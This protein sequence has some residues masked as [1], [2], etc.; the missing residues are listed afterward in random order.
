MEYKPADIEKKWQDYWEEIGLFRMDP[1]D[2]KPKFYCLMMFP[3]PSGTLHVGHM[4]NY[5]IGDVLARYKMMKGFNV[6]SP[7]GWD[8]FGLP[9]ENAAI[10]QNV[11]PKVSTYN[12]IATIKRQL[13]EWGTGYDWDREIASCAPDY[14]KWTQWMFLKLY[15]RGLAYRKKAEVNWCPSCQTVLANEQV[16][17]EKCERC[18]ASVEKKDLE[19]W[20]FK[21]TDYA[22]RLLDDL[23]KLTRWPERVKIMQRNWIGRSEGV[24][25]DFALEKTG[26]VIKCFTTRVDTLFGATFMVMA[27]EHPMVGS[28]IEDAPNRKEIE[29]F[30]RSCRAEDKTVRSS[31]DAV[32]RGIF[33]GKYAINPINDEKVPIYIANYVLMD[34]GTGA[35]MAVP[36]HDERDFQFAKEYGIP[37]KVV[38]QNEKGTLEV[39]EMEHAYEGDG[40]L[41]NSGKFDGMHNRDE[42]MG[43]MTD[44][45]VEIG[46]GRRTVH[47]RLRD[48]LI[49]RQRYWGAPIPMVYCEKCGIVPVDEKD[50]PVILPEE[51]DFKPKGKSPLGDER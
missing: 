3:Y 11:H 6:L 34:Y 32:K 51:V 18:S 38:I 24:E 25:M 2:P 37:V 8:A 31:E 7:I 17:E 44:Y 27:A 48:W 47:Y 33:T 43:K 13:K 22:E 29:D 36:A 4:R 40:P 30:V 23:A 20:F 19:Q 9:A 39:S 35:I 5:V 1:A 14:Y 49:S 50:L 41:V 21:I 10:K 45:L 26:E 12:N 15:E 28:I 42:G 46:K 16:V